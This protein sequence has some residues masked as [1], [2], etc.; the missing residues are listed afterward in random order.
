MTVSWVSARA[1]D[2]NDGPA[3]VVVKPKRSSIHARGLGRLIKLVEER[4]PNL[5]K[6]QADLEIAKLNFS[7]AGKQ[8]FPSL[9]F[10]TQNGHGV[11]D[12][13]P[14][15][16][17]AYASGVKL[18]LT[19]N[20][21]DNGASL[22]NYQIARSTYDR[23]KIEFEIARDTQLMN[24]CTAYYD[25][26]ASSHLREILESKRELLRRQ[27][28]VL[29]TLYKHG[30][31]TKRDV[32]RI[33]TEIRRNELDIIN[34]D[35]DADLN[36][37]KLASLVGVGRQELEKEEIEAEEPKPF[38][39]TEGTADI[40]KPRD[41]RQARVLDFKKRE[42]VLATDLVRRN[43]WPQV[44][45]KGDFGYSNFYYLYNGNPSPWDANHGWTWSALLTVSYNIWDFGI[46]RTQLEVAR[47]KEKQVND[48]SEQELLDLGNDL[49]NVENQLRAFRENV[50]MTRELLVLEQQ[51]YSILEA[52]YRNGRA[53][54]LDLI[55]NL[56]SLIDARS[57]FNAS[58]YGLKKQQVLYS[59][60]QGDLYEV[61]KQK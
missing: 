6:A 51:S 12:A 7:I 61:L 16:P 10:T 21:Y 5:Q 25:W 27:H 42:A 58:Y 1:E 31:K 34:A 14:A 9:D 53:Q 18:A 29:E 47:V 38:V 33:E 54:Y 8:W 44:N 57:K 40:V 30:I 41:H 19:E 37:Q 36:F 24:V 60:H 59:F 17:S 13:D 55:L 11:T 32:L 43:Y 48:K 45:L 52:E 20:L 46:R 23:A 15:K 49:R 3:P 22:T 2:D 4:S 50:R 35:N 39:R 28:A 56:N 26:S